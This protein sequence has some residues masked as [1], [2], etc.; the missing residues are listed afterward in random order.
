L[1]RP[2]SRRGALPTTGFGLL[3]AYNR[4]YRGH[5]VL[6]TLYALIG[7]A[8]SA[9]SPVLL[10]RAVDELLGGLRPNVL[11]LYAVGLIALAA[12]LAVF[13]YL[14]RMLTGGIA[15]G[16][17][18]Q[19]SQDLFAQLLLLD[20]ATLLRYGTGDLLSRATNDFIAI[21][22][23]FSAGFQM[24]MHALLLLAIG[25]VL[26]AL[27]SPPLAALVIVMLTLS[28]ATQFW[29]GRVLGQDHF[30]AARMLTAFGQEAAATDAFR[31]VNEAYTRRSL[32]WALRANAIAP[33]P[34]QV[35]RLATAAVLAFGG[36]LTVEGRLTVGEY[37]QFITYLG[38]LSGAAQQFSQ[39]FERLQQGVAGAQRIGEILRRRPVVADHPEA[40]D[41]PITGALRFAG[42]GV[43]VDGRWV[44]RDITLDVPAGTTLA[45]V[46]AVGAGKS[47]LLSLVARVRDP[48]EGCLL[49]DGHDLRQ[50][51]LDALRRAVGV[52]PQEPLLFS[53]P[54]RDNIT[55]GLVDVPPERVM[56]AVEA[57][58]LSKDL[59]QLPAGLD[60][61]VGE[62]GATL[63][64][65]QKQRTALA[66][67]LV[68][69]GRILLLDDALASVDAHTAAEITEALQQQRRNRT[70]LLVSQRITPI[71]SADQIVVLEEG[72]IVEQG[73]HQSL[74]ALG[75]HYAAIYRREL[76]QAEDEVA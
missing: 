29:L 19:M 74:L 16:V 36:L 47:T 45:I 10:G 64:G 38:L 6:G 75:G 60:T 61:L 51:R 18:Y 26:M 40:V 5:L 65:G 22:R 55:L 31:Q 33:L 41:A 43:K 44:L 25:T 20:R 24:S 52:V 70:C 27:S 30:G 62:R 59:A 12:T 67:A 66:R 11:A 34:S 1:A 63:S 48:D 2:P 8:A 46:G 69:E 23:F 53:M 14:L 7:A 35:V 56:A 68:R 28:L 42:V 54:L 21:W 17:S 15:A 4:P 9:F 37:I 32:E 50:L 72:R 39:A 73:T 58:R 57:A 3:M 49:I 76:R 13:R 71:R